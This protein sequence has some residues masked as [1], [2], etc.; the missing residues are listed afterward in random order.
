M[1]AKGHLARRPVSN[2]SVQ[3]ALAD[4]RK[5][6]TDLFSGVV[7][8]AMGAIMNIEL[9]PAHKSACFPVGE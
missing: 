3:T 7:L 5:L 1:P 9:F 2:F 8:G 4:H 6:E